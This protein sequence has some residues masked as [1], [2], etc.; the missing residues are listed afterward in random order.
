MSPDM[1]K[2]VAEAAYGC[3]VVVIIAAIGIGFLLGRCL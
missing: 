1:F 3:V 2:G